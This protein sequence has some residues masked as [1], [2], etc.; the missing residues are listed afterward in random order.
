M[1]VDENWTFEEWQGNIIENSFPDDEYLI[2]ELSDVSDFSNCEICE[3]LNSYFHFFGKDDMDIIYLYFLSQKTQEEMVDILNKTQPAISYDVNRIRKQIE[4]V[5]ELI[6]HIDN[7][8]LFIVD[9]RTPLSTVEREM[10]TVFFFST[11]L[12]KTST[13]LGMNNITCRSHLMQ[14]I[15]KL[16]ELGYYKEHSMFNFIWSNLNKVKKKLDNE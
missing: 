4:F 5:T 2:E 8:I 10:L 12:I 15:D 14:T 16:R 7:F 13:V 9:E 11:S 6:S 3:H 1:D